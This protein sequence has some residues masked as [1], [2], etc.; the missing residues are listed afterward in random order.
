MVH[1]EVLLVDDGGGHA[2]RQRDGAQ[3][4]R[5]EEAVLLA[6]QHVDLRGRHAVTRDLELERARCRELERVVAVAR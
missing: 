2:S 1:Q 5:G 3:P 6:R 4:E